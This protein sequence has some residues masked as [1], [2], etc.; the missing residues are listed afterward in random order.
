MQ[1]KRKIGDLDLRRGINRAWYT[2]ISGSA[3]CFKHFDRGHFRWSSH[4]HLSG[5]QIARGVTLTECIN[6]TIRSLE[7]LEGTNS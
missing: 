2:N 3:V 6:S 7:S 4:H 5:G 1:M